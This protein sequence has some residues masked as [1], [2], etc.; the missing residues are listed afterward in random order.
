L[1]SQER[2]KERGWNW[3]QK[4]SL[5]LFVHFQHEK[6]MW[7]QF[8]HPFPIVWPILYSEK[9]K[10]DIKFLIFLLYRPKDRGLEPEPVPEP[11]LWWGSS[12]KR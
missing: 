11:H 5:I 4:L 6:M 8:W 2:P 12:M 9:S 7:L 1:F 10:V 3:S